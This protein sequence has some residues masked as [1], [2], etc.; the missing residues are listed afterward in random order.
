MYN[1]VTDCKTSRSLDEARKIN[2][3]DQGLTIQWSR[4]K[5]KDRASRRNIKFTSKNLNKKEIPGSRRNIQKRV[6]S[7]ELRGKRFKK[8]RKSTSSRSLGIFIQ[9]QDSKTEKMAF[10]FANV[11]EIEEFSKNR[12]RD[13]YVWGELYS[14]L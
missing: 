14:P 1:C 13:F 11:D 6:V 10:L 9:Y 12:F 4:Y 7:Q 3:V 5:A 8:E 2:T